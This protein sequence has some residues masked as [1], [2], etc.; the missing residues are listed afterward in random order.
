MLAQEQMEMRVETSL[1]LTNMITEKRRTFLSNIIT[2]DGSELSPSSSWK[3]GKP[4]FIKDKVYASH[5]K[6]M[7]TA[8][9]DNKGMSYTW[10]VPRSIT[11]NADY[12]VGALRKF[13]N[14][15]KQHNLVPLEWQQKIRSSLPKTALSWFLIPFDPLTLCLMT[16]SPSQYS[17]VSLWT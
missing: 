9:S 4:G 10:S 13:L 8:L 7:V 12:I 11:V 16:F 2:I 5:T 14:H 17:R 3:N 1:A 6:E 15:Q